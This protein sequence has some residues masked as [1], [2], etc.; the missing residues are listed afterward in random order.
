MGSEG[1]QGF[2]ET[3][4]KMGCGQTGQTGRGEVKGTEREMDRE[5]Q[6]DREIGRA[7][8]NQAE[9]GQRQKTEWK[10]RLGRR[11]E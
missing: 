4:W 10:E 6:A 9:T 8:G 1:W 11:R 2:R 7:E 3:E 5:G